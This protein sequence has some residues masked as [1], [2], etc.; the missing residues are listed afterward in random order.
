MDG[1]SPV[2]HSQGVDAIKNHELRPY[3][4]EDV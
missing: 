3:E 2:L 1:P 4:V